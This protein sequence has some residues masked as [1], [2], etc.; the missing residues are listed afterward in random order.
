MIQIVKEKELWDTVLKDFDSV[1]FHHTYDYHV[2]DAKEHESPILI[3]YR[4]NEKKIALPLLLRPIP[5]T[6]YNDATSVYGYSGPLSQNIDEQFDNNSFLS[7]LQD[8]VT[9]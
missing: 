9:S 1:D 7:A 6:D 5:N 3:L 4:E 2:L 8:V